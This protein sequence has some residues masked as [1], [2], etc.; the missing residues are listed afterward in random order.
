MAVF[1]ICEWVTEYLGRCRRKAARSLVQDSPLTIPQMVSV[2][3]LFGSASASP[4]I[5]LATS[6]IPVTLKK[7]NSP[8][9]LFFFFRVYLPVC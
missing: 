1:Y 8:E 5:S 3:R 6:P 2:A 4:H 9:G 7:K